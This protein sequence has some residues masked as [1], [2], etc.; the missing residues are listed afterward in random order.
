MPAVGLAPILP[1]VGLAPILPAVGFWHT[2]ACRSPEYRCPSCTVCLRPRAA[3]PLALLAVVLW[4]FSLLRE[5]P[6]PAPLCRCLLLR[7][8]PLAPPTQQLGLRHF[9]IVGSRWVLG[10]HGAAVYHN[11]V[12]SLCLVLGF[13]HG[14]TTELFLI[15]VSL[16][17]V[18]LFGP[19]R[20]L[21]CVV[22]CAPLRLRSAAIVRLVLT[23]IFFLVFIFSC[24]P[25]LVF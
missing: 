25:P 16:A 13:C 18:S 5:S 1:A 8:S 11:V 19:R 10:L 14:N 12:R 22:W 7:S 9:V 2:D 15:T 6:L 23:I 21:R 20:L 17:E 3:S 4:L 24:M